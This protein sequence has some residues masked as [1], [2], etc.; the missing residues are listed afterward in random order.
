MTEP[1][2]LHSEVVFPI[3]L[4]DGTALKVVKVRKG[5]LIGTLNLVY[6]SIEEARSSKIAQNIHPYGHDYKIMGFGELYIAI[7]RCKD[8][9]YEANVIDRDGNLMPSNVALALEVIYEY[10]IAPEYEELDNII[11]NED[12][13]LALIYTT[14]FCEIFSR[15]WLASACLSAYFLEYD[16]FAF[17]Q[18]YSMLQLKIDHELDALRGKKSVESA[19]SGGQARQRAFAAER[20]E[21]LNKME[22]LVDSGHSIANSARLAFNA[23][24][25]ASA[26]ANRRAWSRY[27]KSK[28]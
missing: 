15:E 8:V 19:S 18:L 3:P 4:P 7:F 20:S 9:L 13:W 26:E 10:E 27:R 17:G 28:K 16:D 1:L 11:K 2:K 6:E 21:I 23:G 24:R 25:G 22:E 14:H 12:A 5:I